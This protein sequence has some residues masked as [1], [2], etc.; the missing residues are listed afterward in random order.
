MLVLAL[1]PGPGIVIV[2]ART[3]SQ[4]LR[5]GVVT[6]LGILS[7]DF[8]FI[9]LAI[10]GLATLAQT[11]GELFFWVKVIGAIYLIGLGISIM[12]A[13]S[14]QDHALNHYPQLGNY[15]A[16]LVT[17]LSNPK[18]VLF[19]MSFFPTFLDLSLVSYVDA[20]IILL[21]ATLAI[22]SVMFAYAYL[23]NK[24]GKLVKT[25]PAAKFI[26]YL[27]GSLL[28]GTGAYIASK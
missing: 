16:G 6:I 4:G 19:Y 20:F 14:T 26:K 23:V 9:F 7:A 5:A 27:S 1:L 22:G 21:I 15:I 17:T 3:L 28:I 18:A 24:T 10:L 8:I 11:M 25:S 13:R 2:V 12:R